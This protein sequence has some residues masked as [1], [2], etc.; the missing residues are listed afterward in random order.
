MERQRV[1]ETMEKEEKTGLGMQHD[2]CPRSQ[3]EP[4]DA[5]MRGSMSNRPSGHCGLWAL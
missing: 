4:N 1:G 2:Y 3:R 5:S